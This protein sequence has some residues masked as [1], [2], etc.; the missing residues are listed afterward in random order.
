[1]GRSK[2]S[3]DHTGIPSGVR[4][5]E[6]VKTRTVCGLSAEVSRLQRPCISKRRTRSYEVNHGGSA[7][8]GGWIVVR[9]FAA[10]WFVRVQ[11]GRQ[12]RM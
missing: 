5:P 3:A 9:A 12:A 4:V 10:R 6:F 7:G 2:I 8:G 1:M 11:A